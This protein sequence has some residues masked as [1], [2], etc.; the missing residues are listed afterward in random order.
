MEEAAG[1]SLG[2]TCAR[3]LKVE[4]SGLSRSLPGC[5]DGLCNR[6]WPTGQVLHHT[7]LWALSSGQEFMLLYTLPEGAHAHLSAALRELFP[8]GGQ[9]RAHRAGADSS[10]DGGA[11]PR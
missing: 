4:N 6:R 8:G 11:E 2:L 9:L 7:W 5:F 3:W 1:N 10:Q